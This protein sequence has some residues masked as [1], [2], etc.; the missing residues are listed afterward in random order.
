MDFKSL[1]NHHIPLID[2]RAPVEFDAGHFPM[3][4]NL[5]LLTDEERK[6]VGTR[7]KEVGQEAAIALGHKLVNGS[8]KEERVARWI[9]AKKKYPNAL[10]YCFR[11]G[12]RSHISQQW[13]KEAGVE[14][15]IVPGGY[16]A[17]R[18]FLLETIE[19]ETKDRHFLILAGRTGSGKTSLLKKAQVERIDLEKNANHKGSSFGIVGPQPSQV[20]F[21]NRLAVDFLHRGTSSYILLEDESV[22]IGSV[23]VP[24]GLFQKMN[25]SPMIV[26]EKSLD[27]RVE[28]IVNE[29]VLEN[30]QTLSFMMAALDRIKKRLGGLNYS[31]IAEQM[32]VAFES[33]EKHTM[34]AH[35]PWVESLLL[36]YYDQFYDRS[37][38]RNA[39]RVVFQGNEEECL[40]YLRS[41]LGGK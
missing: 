39:S 19:R 18:R 32:K 40:G 4:I 29:Y 24:K 41:K 15:E 23:N 30:N 13:M 36:H 22:M 9:E 8:I 2:V 10:L 33:P 1:F 31:R 3:S 17:L 35:R 12:L 16:K 25:E 34:N 38:K 27:E 20:T 28:H 6:Q 26:L 7:Y 21:E 37:L 14:I 5:P 11:G